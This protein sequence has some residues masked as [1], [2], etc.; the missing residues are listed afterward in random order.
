MIY[1]WGRLQAEKIGGRCDIGITLGYRAGSLS[2]GR[3]HLEKVLWAAD[4]GCFTNPVLA[5]DE[6]IAWL[7]NLSE[8]HELCLFATAPDV[9]ADAKVA[10]NLDPPRSGHLQREGSPTNLWS[11]RNSFLFLG[12]SGPCPFGERAWR[13][14]RSAS[15][16]RLKSRPRYRKDTLTP[17]DA[18]IHPEIQTSTPGDRSVPFSVPVSAN[19]E[20]PRDHQG[21]RY[22]RNRR[23]S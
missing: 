6:Y 13:R 4:N 9:V 12:R 20:R 21:A 8:F 19:V 7:K 2:H 14:K 18:A 11:D 23:A 16:A 3:R 1:L 10:W 17:E 22:E 15:S 5:V